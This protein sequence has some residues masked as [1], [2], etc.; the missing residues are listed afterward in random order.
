MIS[1]RSLLIVLAAASGGKQARPDSHITQL[2]VASVA[3][4][5]GA[6]SG[7]ALRHTDG[8]GRCIAGGAAT[9]A[10]H[11]AHDAMPTRSKVSTAHNARVSGRAKVGRQQATSRNAVSTA[12]YSL[13]KATLGPHTAFCWGDVTMHA[14]YTALDQCTTCAV[15][16]GSGLSWSFGADCSEKCLDPRRQDGISATRECRT[17][18]HPH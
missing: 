13:A 4:E 10:D 11:C 1:E 9:E 2:V 17:E 5:I 6:A 3:P 7:F 16:R 12:T 18:N 8:C 14:L 15:A